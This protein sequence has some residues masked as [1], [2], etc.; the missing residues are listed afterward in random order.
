M[1]KFSFMSKI[2]LNNAPK[3]MFLLKQISL[4]LATAFVLVFAV[5]AWFAGGEGTAKATGIQVT[6]T[7][8][9]N[10]LISLNGGSDFRPAI[11]LM[12]EDDQQ[13][14]SPENA[15]KDLLYMRDITS[16]GLSFFRPEFLDNDSSTDRTPDP[17]KSW[18]AAGDNSYI[19]LSIVFQT[20]NPSNIYL[21]EDTSFITSAEK[22]G[23]LL[24][25][26]ESENVGNNSEF[27]KAETGFFS[28]DCI[29]GALRLSAVNSNNNLVYVYIPR[30]D[31]EMTKTITNG[32]T[33]YAVNTGSE[34]VTNKTSVH[35]YYKSVN[36]TSAPYYILEDSADVVDSLGTN[37]RPIATTTLQE[38][39]SCQAT[40][41]INIWLEG[42]DPETTRALSKGQYSI[43]LDFTASPVN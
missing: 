43:A 26:N 34:N 8:N 12:A 41:T 14:I 33:S 7:A 13:Y 2:K 28:N 32:V 36:S 29:V 35:T 40:A 15:I 5:F 6:M 4:L 24:S 3:K 16:D 30:K 31:I 39:G 10:M 11:D 42:C 23:K 9:N 1:K 19:S 25:S 20:A 27:G 21:S 37:P 17:Y 22:S 18:D 38:G